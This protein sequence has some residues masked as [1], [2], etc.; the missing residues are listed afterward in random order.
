[1]ANQTG[2]N[3]WVIDTPGASLISAQDMHAAH[4]E[5][6]GY[7]AQADSVQVKDRFGKIVWEATGKADLSLVESFTLEW[8]YGF[9]V[10]TLTAGR[11][12]LFYE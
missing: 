10:T 6:A 7:A 5:W 8:L 12:R 2:S 1:M 9:A 4:F 11:L 3:P